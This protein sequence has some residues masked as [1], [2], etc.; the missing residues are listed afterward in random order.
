[1]EKYQAR[2]KILSSGIY[3]APQDKGREAGIAQGFSPARPSDLFS[4]TFG[5]AIL[6]GDQGATALEIVLQGPTL[7]CV[8]GSA[9][10]LVTGAPMPVFIDEVEQSPYQIL[11][12]QQGQTLSFGMAKEGFRS[13]L[14]I[15][16]G[17]SV[18]TL[19]GSSSYH[20]PTKIGG[21]NGLPLPENKT[22]SVPQTNLIS[23]KPVGYVFSEDFFTWLWKT[24]TIGILPGSDLNRFPDES[25]YEME[26]QQ[27]EIR[28]DSNRMGIR[29]K[30]E[31][32][33]PPTQ[34]EKLSEPLGMG[35]IQIP[36]DGNPI[37]MMGDHQTIGGYPIF[38]K[39][40]SAYL[41]CLGQVRLG[42]HIKFLWISLEQSQ[43]QFFQAWDRI[44]KI[45]AKPVPLR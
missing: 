3:C 17:F 2:F 39:V 13:Y 27:F 30:G 18:P 16:G 6:N 4:Y 10:F 38:A 44:R 40:S 34:F 15:V 26:T 8:E 21:F 43:E 11:L 35:S 23:L 29:L 33:I 25:K 20:A 45:T 22:L 12:I 32:A 24:T 31:R 28:A 36:K 41:P 19:L 5:D 1:M 37:V 7:E 14:H 9:I 42:N